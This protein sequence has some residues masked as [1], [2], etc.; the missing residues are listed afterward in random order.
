MPNHNFYNTTT[1]EYSKAPLGGLASKAIAKEKEAIDQIVSD[2]SFDLEQVHAS[3]TYLEEKLVPVS[4]SS[5][6][7]EPS[8]LSLPYDG[9]SP[10]YERLHTIR[11]AVVLSTERINDFKRRVEV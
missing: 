11:R 10:L 2:L 3:L 5:P 7:A 4:S 6:I 9:S 8:E 1:N